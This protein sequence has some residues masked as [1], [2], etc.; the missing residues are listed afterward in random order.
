MIQLKNKSELER[1]RKACQIS[2]QALQ[3]AG[4]AIKVGMT[5]LELDRIIHRFIVSQ[6][7][8]PSFLGYGGFP[9]T[10]CIS[11][12]NEVIHGIPSSARVLN[13]GDIVSVDVG[14][15][16][17]GFHGDNAATF[18][19]GTV[20]PEAQKLLDVTRDSLYKGIEAAIAGNRIGDIGC[21]VQTY[22]EENGFAVV[23]QYIGHGVGHELHE[24]PEVP[25]FGRAGRGVRLLPGMTIAIE[26]MVNAVGEGVRVLDDDWTVV[27][28]S[29]SLSAHFEHT[30]AITEHGPVILTTP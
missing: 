9:G 27:T 26:P 25:N 13:E 10:A 5:T 24:D 6:G 2:A 14:A 11:V 30:I 3:V 4:E 19:V 22:V 16:Y 12:N 18:A 17:D 28:K 29:G 20:S 21:A 7:A 1:M 15:F 8:K 23:R